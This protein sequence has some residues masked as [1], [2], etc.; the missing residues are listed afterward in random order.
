MTANLPLCCSRQICTVNHVLLSMSIYTSLSAKVI[1]VPCVSCLFRIVTASH[2]VCA[3]LAGWARKIERIGVSARE[4][5][6][7]FE[8]F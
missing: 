7:F 5:S 3:I 1:S 8:S 2:T 6:G 4:K